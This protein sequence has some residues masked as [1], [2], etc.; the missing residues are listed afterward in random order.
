MTGSVMDGEDVVQEALFEAYRKLDKFDESC[1]MKACLFRMA[2]NRSI[3]LRRRG[4]R[5]EAE[6]AAVAMPEATSSAEPACI[7]LS[8]REP[9]T[10]GA[11]ICA[12]FNMRARKWRK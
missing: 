7:H 5:D 8:P 12:K 11:P 6:A 1:P 4:V 9:E 2:H 3:D 10:H